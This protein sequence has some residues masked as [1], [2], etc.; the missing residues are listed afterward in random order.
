[1]AADQFDPLGVGLVQG[2]V[3][4]DRKAALAVNQRAG[5]PLED[6]GVGLDPAEEPGEGVMRRGVG[7]TPLPGNS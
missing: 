6:L 3:V 1:M 2:R 4:E 5:L 7:A